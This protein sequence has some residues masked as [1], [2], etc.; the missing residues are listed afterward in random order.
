MIARYGT[1]PSSAE[2]KSLGFGASGAGCCA[3][4]KTGS[5]KGWNT[6]AGDEDERTVREGKISTTIRIGAYVGF[7]LSAGDGASIVSSKTSCASSKM[8]GIML[9]GAFSRYCPRAIRYD[10]KQV[11][12]RYKVS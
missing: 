1:I 12:S 3:L 11:S 10:G 8:P 6:R 9:Q 4:E 2:V 7:F 5:V